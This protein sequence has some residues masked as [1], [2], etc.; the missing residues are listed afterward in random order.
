M[1]VVEYV[2]C[3]EFTAHCAGSCIT[4]AAGCSVSCILR[5]HH[6]W[7]SLGSGGCLYVQT[8]PS[9][10]LKHFPLLAPLLQTH[11]IVE[12][13]LL[14]LQAAETSSQP[15]LVTAE[16]NKAVDNIMAK[17]LS[18]IQLQA[19]GRTGMVVACRS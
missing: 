9:T 7:T 13:V 11:T 4:G 15:I 17:L 8:S 2:K 1:L 5:V 18:R 14:A 12:I 3:Q 19:A 10:L 16:T 6:S